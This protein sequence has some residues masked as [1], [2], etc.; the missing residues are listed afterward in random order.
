M[1]PKSVTLRHSET[2]TTKV[3]SVTEPGVLCFL[4]GHFRTGYNKE[5]DGRYRCSDCG[6]IIESA[7]Q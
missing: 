4:L 2:G 1:K 5:S 7:K 3:L 6:N